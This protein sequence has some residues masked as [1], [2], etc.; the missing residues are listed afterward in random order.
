LRAEP[1][2]ARRRAAYLHLAARHLVSTAGQ[3]DA[4]E[5]W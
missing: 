4:G 3:A 2:E 1:L 5:N